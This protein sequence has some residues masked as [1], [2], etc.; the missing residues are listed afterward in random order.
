VP[1]QVGTFEMASEQPRRQAAGPLVEVT[2]HNARS[3][4]IVPLQDLSADQHLSLSS[5]FKT[6]GSQMHI[7]DVKRRFTYRDIGSQ[8]STSLATIGAYVVITTCPHVEPAKQ[9]IAVRRAVDAAI[10]AETGVIAELPCDELRLIFLSG[11]WDPHYFLQ[12]HDIGI[13]FAQYFNDPVGPHSPVQSARFVDVV[14]CYPDPDRHFGMLCSS[15]LD[16]SMSL[17]SGLVPKGVQ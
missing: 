4:Q 8:A 9:K 3:L 16:A 6:T 10:F 1:L 14:G 13:D 2:Q 5:A 11:I 7:E 12:G 15:I 17:A